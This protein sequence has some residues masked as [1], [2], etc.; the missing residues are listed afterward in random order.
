MSLSV[1]VV[2]LKAVGLDCLRA[3]D[4]H[5]SAHLQSSDGHDVASG[6]TE[7][8]MRGQT[9]ALWNEELQLPAWGDQVDIMLVELRSGAPTDRHAGSAESVV[10]FVSLNWSGLIRLHKE[11]FVVEE[12]LCGRDGS[13]L[14]AHLLLRLRKTDTELAR[15]MMSQSRALLSDALASS[16]EQYASLDISA[17]EARTT[18]VELCSGGA[19]LLQGEAEHA[20]ELEIS[21]F[22]GTLESRLHTTRSSRE[23]VLNSVNDILARELGGG[24]YATVAP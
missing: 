16:V 14:G 18:L 5:I 12:P 1:K 13:A 20:A 17:C 3:K 23:M 11:A 6:F 2:G 4:L 9:A 21:G 10:G 19:S 8:A 22:R 24:M 15:T 7:V